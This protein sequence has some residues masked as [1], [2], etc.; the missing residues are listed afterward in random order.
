MAENTQKPRRFQ[1]SLRTVFV[2]MTVAAV[3]VA[4]SSPVFQVVWSLLAAGIAVSF[5]LC[6]GIGAFTGYSRNGF[7][8]GL[9]AVATVL[10]WVM[11]YFNKVVHP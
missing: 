1:F 7:V 6:M 11:A 4:V 3:L 10:L 8:V 9:F 5:L 2:V